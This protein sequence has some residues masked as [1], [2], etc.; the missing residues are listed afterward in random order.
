MCAGTVVHKE[1]WALISFGDTHIVCLLVTSF[2]VTLSPCCVCVCVCVCVCANIYLLVHTA[3]RI[4]Y[5]INIVLV[6]PNQA[7]YSKKRLTSSHW[8]KCAPLVALRGLT[9]SHTL[10]ERA[11]RR[12]TFIL[13]T[14]LNFVSK[15]PY[16]LSEKPQLPCADSLILTR[17]P[18]ASKEPYIL[19]KE[20][21]VPFK[22]Q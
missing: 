7:R 18:N 14:Q 20:R 4:L 2:A 17:F 22:E 6:S 9:I 11:K 8:L 1:R 16:I 19:S 15:N 13:S 5:S 3:K 12:P 21:C 10:P